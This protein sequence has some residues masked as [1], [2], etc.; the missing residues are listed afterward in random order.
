MYGGGDSA[1]VGG[2][3]VVHAAPTWRTDSSQAVTA[4]ASSA[5]S[6]LPGVQALL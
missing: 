2:M 5:A 4:A 1:V 6:A 3:H